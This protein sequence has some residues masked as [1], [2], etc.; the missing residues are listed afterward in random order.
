M[1]FSSS[2]LHRMET[3]MAGDIELIL[4]ILRTGKAP[5]GPP[6]GHG[7][8]DPVRPGPAPPPPYAAVPNAIPGKTLYVP[9]TPSS[10]SPFFTLTHRECE[11]FRPCL[12]ENFEKFEMLST[13]TGS[14][15]R[16][17]RRPHQLP[18]GVEIISNFSKFHADRNGTV[19]TLDGSANSGTCMKNIVR[20]KPLSLSHLFLFSRRHSV[21]ELGG[22]ESD[23]ARP[24]GHRNP[25]QR[26]RKSSYRRNAGI[27]IFYYLNCHVTHTVTWRDVTLKWQFKCQ[28]RFRGW[29]SRASAR[30]Q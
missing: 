26:S 29:F 25:A 7:R 28:G 24:G 23:R 5:T 27:G 12:H 4:S 15:I 11:Q 13:P 21:A 2:R 1:L 22:A 20:K 14:W 3:K 30:H 8:T 9:I 17:R 19:H 16:S 6:S 18:V 10:A